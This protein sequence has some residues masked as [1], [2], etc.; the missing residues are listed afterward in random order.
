MINKIILG[1]VQLGLS[2][3][4]NN[5]SG[6]PSE[7][8]AFDILDL[9]YARGIDWLDSADAYGDSIEVISR[10]HKI[11]NSRFKISNKFKNVKKG[12]LKYIVENSL[13]RLDIPQFEVY[14]FHSFNDYLNNRVILSDLI[15]LKSKELIKK[16][17]ISVYTNAE[18]DR[19]IDDVNIDVI[20]LP[21]NI[22]DNINL[23]G[24][25]LERAKS[26]GKEIHI[27][28]VFL[29]GLFFMEFNRFPENL[30]PLKPYIQKILDFCKTESLSMQTLALSY[31]LYNKNI[32]NV[33]I[34]VEN[35]T[36]LLKNIES[37]QNHQK[38]FDFINNSVFVKETE[39]LNPVNWK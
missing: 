23:R 14:S 21:Y 24:S 9:A 12:E 5:S 27:R 1:T 35:N 39:L 3:G 19:V 31:A 37:I 20:Q 2:Y 16:T 34:G 18:L 17:G 8:E 30:S 6:K 29:Q 13:K 28:S 32:D 22:L 7:K 38:A 15:K 4:I 25:L 33:L 10:Y 36:Q 11:S 26:Q